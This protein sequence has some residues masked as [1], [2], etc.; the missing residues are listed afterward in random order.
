[1]GKIQAYYYNQTVQSVPATE[2]TQSIPKFDNYSIVVV[3]LGI[4]IFE[5]FRR[6]NLPSLK[7]LNGIA[8][9]TFMIY[10]IHDNGFAYSLWETQDWIT[11]LYEDFWGFMAKLGIWT[12][13]VFVTGLV[14]YYLFVLGEKLLKKCKILF[15]KE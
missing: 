7:I 13:G 6:I 1:M 2:F 11:L 8:K 4:C 12:L 3:I 15:I 9:A 14:A 10:L 5:L